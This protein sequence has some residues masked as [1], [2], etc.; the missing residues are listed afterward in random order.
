MPQD[1]SDI[2]LLSLTSKMDLNK[3][4][5]ASNSSVFS[6]SDL[7]GT[8]YPQGWSS[9]SSF[10]WDFPQ[11]GSLSALN[12]LYFCFFPFFPSSSGPWLELELPNLWAGFVWGW[13][14]FSCH[15]QPCSGTKPLPL[16]WE[17][18]GWQ[19]TIW[20]LPTGARWIL[21][22]HKIGIFSQCHNLFLK[23]WE[24]LGLLGGGNESPGAAHP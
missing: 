16:L 23:G 11:Q 21:L 9:S 1:P 8:V 24:I 3:K 19:V 20:H 6:P 14:G 17:P 18:L 4:K 7:G 5:T 13:K 12:A 2:C 15:R 10:C 22:C